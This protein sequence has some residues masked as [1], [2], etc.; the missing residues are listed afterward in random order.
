LKGAT[1]Q[2]RSVFPACAAAQYSAKT[3]ADQLL[4]EKTLTTNFFEVSRSWFSLFGKIGIQHG[5]WKLPSILITA[6]ED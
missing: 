4:H 5:I 3:G 1:S 2:W 6:L